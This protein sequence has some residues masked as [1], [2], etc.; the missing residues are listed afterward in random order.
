[1]SKKI[2]FLTST[3]DG[4][5]LFLVGGSFS[6]L[7]PTV[8]VAK[9]SVKELRDFARECGDFLIKYEV[10]RLEEEMALYKALC[11]KKFAADLYLS[12]SSAQRAISW[13]QAGIKKKHQLI[14]LE[15]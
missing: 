1:M 13:A 15:E 10:H 3:I 2:C 9:Q 6:T 4:K 8:K 7:C 12:A 5:N 14:K 11:A